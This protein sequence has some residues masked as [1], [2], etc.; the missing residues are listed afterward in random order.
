[1]DLGDKKLSRLN[2][3]ALWIGWTSALGVSLVGNFQETQIIYVHLLGALTAFGVGSLYLWLQVHHCSDLMDHRLFYLRRPKISFEMFI[4]R[5]QSIIH[6][7]NP[8]S[9]VQ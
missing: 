1:M 5:L 6:F 3:V 8:Y 4:K 9:K 2:S 7:Y